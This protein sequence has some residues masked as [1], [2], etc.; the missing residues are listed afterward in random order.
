MTHRCCDCEKRSMFSVRTGT[1]MECSKLGYQVWLIAIY[2]YSTGIKGVSS[3][4]PHRDLQV[5]QNTAWF[6]AKRLKKIF[7]DDLTAL[8]SFL[9]PARYHE[10]FRF[11]GWFCHARFSGQVKLVHFQNRDLGGYLN[12]QIQTGRNDQTYHLRFPSNRSSSSE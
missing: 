3:M 9:G 7:E 6:L 10:K 11:D 5:T 4:K 12:C 8:E 2:L 1:A